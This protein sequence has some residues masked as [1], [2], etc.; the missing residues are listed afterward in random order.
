MNKCPVCG[1]KLV[2]YKKTN[3]SGKEITPYTFSSRKV[4]EYMH[5]TLNEC[6][7]CH[8]LYSDCP[9][10]D[11]EI[12]RQYEVASYDSGNEADCASKTYFSYL[13]RYVPKY[14]KGSALDIGTGNGSYLLS[15]KDGGILRTVGVEPSV[16]PIKQADKSIKDDIVNAPFSNE[17]FSKNEFDMI[18]LFQT[19][20]HMPDPLK[21]IGEIKQILKEGGYFYLVCHD[22]LSTANRIMG[23]KSPIYDIEHLQIFSKRGIRK[24]MEKMQFRDIQVFTIKNKY[25]L[26]YWAKLFPLPKKVKRIL[27]K[28]LEHSKLGNMMIGI[29]VGNVGIICKK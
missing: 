23:L 19:I 22:Y 9:I 16:E 13:K 29:N 2:L 24:L 14:P 27:L 18:S 25:S 10:M 21:S 15:L 11:E 5:W 26:K 1:R 7:D 12:F 3:Y 4:P 28:R 17:L 20:E 8:I 6:K